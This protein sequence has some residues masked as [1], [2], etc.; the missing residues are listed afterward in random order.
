MQQFAR[1][2]F[3][4]MFV[5]EGCGCQD[6]GADQQGISQVDPGIQAFSLDATA[7]EAFDPA[8]P[9]KMQYLPAFRIMR[10]QLHL[11]AGLVQGSGDARRRRGNLDHGRSWC[12][13]RLNAQFSDRSDG[14]VT[15]SGHR[16]LRL[17]HAL[18]GLAQGAL[19]GFNSD[20]ISEVRFRGFE[21][22]WD[23]VI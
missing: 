10:R 16:A 21:S 12:R 8:W 11:E 7:M 17:N 2:P 23:S 3:Q 22:P 14:S 19:P 6:Q 20:F 1:D 4:S 9:G 13:C 18:F 5:E 15:S